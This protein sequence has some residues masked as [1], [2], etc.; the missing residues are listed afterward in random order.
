M[1]L[2]LGL[3]RDALLTLMIPTAAAK[4]PASKPIDMATSNAICELLCGFSSVAWLR[5]E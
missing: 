1:R 3:I 5:G 2:D 4:P